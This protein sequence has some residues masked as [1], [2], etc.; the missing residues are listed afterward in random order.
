MKAY[1]ISCMQKAEKGAD[2]SLTEFYFRTHRKKDKD[3][4][5]VGHYQESAYVSIT[6][7]IVHFITILVSNIMCTESHFIIT[8]AAIE[9]EINLCESN[10]RL[11]ESNQRLFE[12][13]QTED[14]VTSITKS[15][16]RINALY[17][18]IIIKLQLTCMFNKW[19]GDAV[20]LNP[21]ARIV[22]QFPLQFYIC[23]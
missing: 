16:H 2:P 1:F 17:Q 23:G 22:R 4:S 18:K 21:S 5:W 13:N 12:S 19:Q 14:R 9:K 15:G 8:N 6:F 3:R 10:Q 7:I 11:C 20:T